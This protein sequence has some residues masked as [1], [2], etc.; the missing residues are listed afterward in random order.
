MLRFNAFR[1]RGLQDRERINVGT[2]R[3]HLAH[4]NGSRMEQQ[5]PGDTSDIVATV[6]EW[7]DHHLSGSETVNPY[8][9]VRLGISHVSIVT[10]MESGMG[11]IWHDIAS[12][13]RCTYSAWL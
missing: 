5:L 8:A 9:D 10:F 3:K 7:N 2:C 1:A 6:D 12:V 4:R 11:E 13:V